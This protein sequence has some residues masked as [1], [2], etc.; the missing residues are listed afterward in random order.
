MVDA[1]RIATSISQ[2]GDSIILSP[3][4][5][6]FDMFTGYGQRGEAFR[7]AVNALI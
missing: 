6:S 1:V 5:S 2:L 3:G 7:A 4:T